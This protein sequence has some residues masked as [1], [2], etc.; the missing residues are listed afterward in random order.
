MMRKNTIQLLIFLLCIM[1]SCGEPTLNIPEYTPRIAVDGYIEAGHTPV[2]YLTYSS[3]F[4]SDYD[5]MDFVNMV[6]FN[7]SAYVITEEDDTI[8]FTRRTNSDE[9][10]PFKYTM[11]VSDLIGEAGKTYRLYIRKGGEEDIRATTTIP[12]YPPEI[13][14]ITF[15]PD[16]LVDTLGNYYLELNNNPDRKFYFIQNKKIREPS[17]Y[18]IK[19]PA[20]S[21]KYKAESLITYKLLRKRNTNLWVPELELNDDSDTAKNDSILPSFYS[22][23]LYFVG[24]TMVFK[25]S[26]LDDES[27]KVLST[28]FLDTEYPN[29]P[30][31]GLSQLPESNISNNIGRWTGM[32]SATK[33]VINQP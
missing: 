5:S 32:N 30:F 10:P 4:I 22:E 26:T 1:A 23:N 20:K 28:I 16:S 15:Q 3:P 9:F 13:V 31:K 11:S 8:G 29:N 17:F 6:K 27:F 24:D 7:V 33:V 21:T 19:F 14:D 2:M 25:V 12:L 18:P